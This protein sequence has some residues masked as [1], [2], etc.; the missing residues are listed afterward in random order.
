MPS[1]H[2]S[3]TTTHPYQMSGEFTKETKTVWF[4]FHGYAQLAKDFI[5]AFKVLKSEHTVLIAP[6]GLSR[7]YLKKFT[8]EI[9]AS[10][11]TTEDREID[12]SNYL[13]YLTAIY[14]A[15]VKPLANRVKLRVL[16]FS[17]GTATASRWLVRSKVSFNQLVLWGGFLAH[18]IGKPSAGRYFDANN[19]T[20]VYGDQDPFIPPKVAQNIRRKLKVLGLD[21][22]IITFE[23]KHEIHAITLKKFLS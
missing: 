19:L 6:Q 15:E 9:G 8:G 1:R 20:L 21:P 7:F 3:I 23:G 10:W 14:D 22:E 5:R 13:A 4:L 2:I 17:Q 11:M 18:E 16:G 12:I